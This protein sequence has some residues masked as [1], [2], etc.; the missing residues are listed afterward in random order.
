MRAADHQVT[1]PIIRNISA[2]GHIDAGKTTL[3]ERLLYHTGGL[4]SSPQQAAVARSLPGDVDDGSTITDFLEQERQRG[5]TI[6][7]A[8]VG[9][10]WWKSM[11]SKDAPAGAITL[12]DTPGHIDFTIE[13]ERSLRVAD[14]CVVVMD[15]VE[16]V[17]AQTEG[18]W[19]IGKR[20]G[21]Q[22]NILFLNKLDRPGSSVAKSLK[23]FVQRGLH[24]RPV[25]LQLPILPSTSSAGEID[26]GIVGVVDLL[27]QEE[28]HFHG[29]AG[30][31]IVRQPI[32]T[33]AL[34]EE[35]NKARHALI[36]TLASLDETLLEELLSIAPGD[37]NREP[38][39][40]VSAQ[41][42]RHCLRRLTT[43]GKVVPT[44]CGSA[45][46]NVGIQPL[47]DAVVDFLPSPAEAGDVRDSDGRGEGIV[48]G[49]RETS[50]DRAS[51]RRHSDAKTKHATSRAPSR[52]AS[53]KANTAAA[54]SEGPTTGS[55]ADL[56]MGEEVR[57][58]VNDANLAI[59]A[60][61]VIWDKRRG[62]LTFVRVYSGTLSTSTTLFNTTT[63]TRERISRV[64]A[65]FGSMHHEISALQPGQVGV[66]MGL[67]DTR[68]GDTLIEARDQKANGTLRL[69][70]VDVPPPVFSVSV[71]ANSRSDEKDVNEALAMLVRTDPSLRLDTGT[72]DAGGGTAFGAA[73]TNQTILSGMGEL[74]LEIAKDR[75]LNEFGVKARIGSVRVSYR[76]TVE[77]HAEAVAV[78][79]VLE[80]EMGGKKVKFGARIT[81]QALEPDQEGDPALENNLVSISLGPGERTI[82]S[83]D[84]ESDAKR[85]RRHKN[86]IEGGSPSQRSGAAQEDSVHRDESDASGEPAL[87]TDNVR[88]SVLGGVTAA[89][90]RGP[91]S[92]HPLT[93][94]HI[95]VSDV[96]LFGPEAS[97]PKAISA[98]TQALVRKAVRE[99]GVRMM[100]PVMRVRIETEEGYLG[101][102]VSDITT[103]Q[104]GDI[105]E[106]EHEDAASEGGEDASGSESQGIDVYVPSDSLTAT[107]GPDG[108]VTAQQSGPAA[109]Q[110]TTIIGLV[111][112]SKLVSYSS[113]LR[114]L[115]GGTGTYTMEL[116]GFRA[117]SD[118]RQKEILEDIGRI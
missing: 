79:E 30:E 61:K 11:S 66:L 47:L 28:L 106:V 56:A 29:R 5:I 53:E 114:A 99:T 44:L 67:R 57:V 73:G 71:S 10:L 103:A 108:G 34:R 110:K 107:A 91:M 94:L 118:E 105:V 14:G 13:V 12:V 64:L 95:R 75:L 76:E 86:A 9:P 117:V 100:E 69:R 111:P 78:N 26:G 27:E 74:H 23:S 112:L 88:R 18:N 16:G 96:Q 45:A 52:T 49:T 1:L 81:V 39:S 97:P 109:R 17:E 40:S 72:D 38:H 2:W 83:H 54:A 31:E 77:E 25:L 43:A 92:S 35:A 102:V 7:S 22:S 4:S 59:L 60:F 87:D 63:G 42:L 20:Y 6:Q 62:P 50:R 65:P 90:S 85:S 15:S 98:L 19:R 32:V 115:T 37:G 51:S 21:V 36:E 33:E 82:G 24:P 80:R 8:A 55:E 70:R 48:F 89:L 3:T 104:K 58:S 101:R 93:K 41:S 113:R 46:K 68:T 116:E 84:N